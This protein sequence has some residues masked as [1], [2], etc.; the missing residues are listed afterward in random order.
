MWS[1]PGNELLWDKL[2]YVINWRVSKVAAGNVV[3][4]CAIENSD[5]FNVAVVVV[6]TSEIMTSP[7]RD[8]RVGNR[9]CTED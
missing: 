7:S 2:K 6:D 4:V 9:G 8:Y 3:L 5:T 1:G